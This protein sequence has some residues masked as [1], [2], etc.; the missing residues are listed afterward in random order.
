MALSAHW[1]THI[2]AWQSS[3]LS[4]AAYCRQHQL[5]YSTFSARLCKFRAQAKSSP[6]APPVLLPI[7][8]QPHRRRRSAGF[9]TMPEVIDWNCPL[10][11]P[12]LGWRSYG[13]AWVNRSAGANLVGRG[14]GRHAPG[15][16]WVIVDCAA[17]ARAFAARGRPLCF[18][19]ALAIA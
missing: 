18:I 10:V 19:I 17:S 15:H 11:C 7:H 9:C 16:R 4:Q 1:K 12:H 3:G 6:S 2:N 13:D 8:V 14:T 5:T